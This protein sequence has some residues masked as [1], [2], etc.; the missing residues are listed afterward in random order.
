MIVLYGMRASFLLLRRVLQNDGRV[1]PFER[2]EQRCFSSG[3][4]PPAHGHSGAAML[5]SCRPVRPRAGASRPAQASLRGTARM[6]L[7]GG[8]MHAGRE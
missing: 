6:G 7:T 1:V 3:A 5:G 8:S 2:E 4:P